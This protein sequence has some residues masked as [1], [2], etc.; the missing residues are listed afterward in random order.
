MVNSMIV[1][2]DN[3][4]TRGRN[5]VSRR[6]K[7]LMAS[8]SIIFGNSS[9]LNILVAVYLRGILTV[10]ITDG[11]IIYLKELTEPDNAAVV[12]GGAVDGYIIG[13]GLSFSIKR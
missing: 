7:S 11:G 10:A 4:L 9:A 13:V 3:G 5:D 1:I 8:F 12:Y 2:V 6:V